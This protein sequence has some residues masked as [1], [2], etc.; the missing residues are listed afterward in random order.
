M[1]ISS[2][3]RTIHFF[4]LGHFPSPLHLEV[5]GQCL[6]RSQ[7]WHL[8]SGCSPSTFFG[9]EV[10]CILTAGELRTSCW[11]G[12][13]DICT[14]LSSMDA[15][16]LLMSYIATEEARCCWSQK[17][18]AKDSGGMVLV[19]LSRVFLHH[20]HHVVVCVTINDHTTLPIDFS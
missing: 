10:K 13:V 15:I 8:Q 11:I 17:R 3:R 2:T 6:M 14:T 5:A 16:S 7:L 4:Q 19:D 12:D 20:R 1:C 18:R 9:A